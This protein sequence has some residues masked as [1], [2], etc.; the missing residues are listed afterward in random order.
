MG[1][2]WGGQPDPEAQGLRW[3]GVAIP[4]DRAGAAWGGTLCLAGQV[5]LCTGR[6]VMVLM[7]TCVFI[8]NNDFRSVLEKIVTSPS[9]QCVQKEAEVG[10]QRTPRECPVQVPGEGWAG[11]R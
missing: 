5:L 3:A 10:L 1:Q 2:L 6:W 11:C 9:I 4:G 8:N 7:Q